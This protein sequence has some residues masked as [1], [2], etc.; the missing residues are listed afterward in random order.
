M[1]LNYGP[2]TILYI[3]KLKTFSFSVKF[4]F[5]D[6]KLY[7]TSSRFCQSTN[8][9]LHE[10][11]SEYNTFGMQNI[12]YLSGFVMNKIV[13]SQATNIWFYELRLIR[14][15]W[16]LLYH[17]GLCMFSETKT[18]AAADIGKQGLSLILAMPSCEVIVLLYWSKK[19][20]Y[21]SSSHYSKTRYVQH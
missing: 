17:C 1:I 8:N 12:R 9:I 7:L 3:A 6:A 20:V 14:E 4:S 19:P 21:N 2:F 11:Q 18:N 10:K 13:S 15:V 16:M 5:S